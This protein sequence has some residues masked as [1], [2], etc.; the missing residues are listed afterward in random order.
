MST[1]ALSHFNWAQALLYTILYS[2][3]FLLSILLFD[4][5]LEC[6]DIGSHIIMAF[7]VFDHSIVQQGQLI[8]TV[9]T[10]DRRLGDNS[11]LNE[12]H[13]H[14]QNLWRPPSGRRPYIVTLSLTVRN[15][16]YNAAFVT[17]EDNVGR[18][19]SFLK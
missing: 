10:P 15:C 12:Q 16:N 1:V 11:V 3:T 5:A 8:M 17:R 18:P 13:E 9:M 7:S 4:F 14:V 6:Q 19:F 2:L